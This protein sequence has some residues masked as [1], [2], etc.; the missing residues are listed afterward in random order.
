MSLGDFGS[1]LGRMGRRTADV[2]K[3][4]FTYDAPPN[5]YDAEGFTQLQ[6]QRARRYRDE[7]ERLRAGGVSEQGEQVV[8]KGRE[9][10]G[11][12][13]GVAKQA[14]GSLGGV[15]QESGERVGGQIMMGARGQEQDVSQEALGKK[16]EQ[17]ESLE[18]LGEQQLLAR[19]A[20]IAQG[21]AQQKASNVGLLT[22]LGSL[23]VQAGDLFDFDFSDK[24]M[25]SDVRDGSKDI[26]QMLDALS[27]KTYNKL[28]REET[29]VMAQDLERTPGADMVKEIAG[30]KGIAMSPTET[31]AI[32]AYQQ[33]KMNEQEERIKALEA[34]LKKKRG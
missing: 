18:S 9:L 12:A 27:P 11:Q 1:F 13:R 28:G 24:R 17:L 32:A 5:P 4:P 7:I 21:E 16:E 10:A 15:S 2:L 3:S 14:R 22:S 33:D 6:G 30:L 25:K 23:A 29:G 26:E 34:M 31:L 19:E 8:R 20:M